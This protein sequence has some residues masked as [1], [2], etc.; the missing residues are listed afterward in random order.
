M[1]KREI[2]VLH[3]ISRLGLE[4]ML[5]DW[6]QREDARVRP[7][8]RLVRRYRTERENMHWHVTG[9]E[10]G[11]GTV[12]VSYAPSLGILLVLVHDNRQGLWAGQAYLR[13]SREIMKRAKETRELGRLRSK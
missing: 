8:G 5:K 7:M 13:L 3:Q 2:V 4:G 10:K 11:M 12:E 9:L 1:Q 6:A